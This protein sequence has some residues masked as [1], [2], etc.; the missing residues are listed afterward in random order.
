MVPAR[1]EPGFEH[2]FQGLFS[3][4]VPGLCSGSNRHRQ[5][6]MLAACIKGGENAISKAV[7]PT[8]R[9]N[10][11]KMRITDNPFRVFSYFL[12]YYP[13]P[14]SDLTLISFYIFKSTRT[15]PDLD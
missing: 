6:S 4:A 5:Q 9:L 7:G 15:R 11:K 14:E 10:G 1:P 8:G 2:D 12:K 13:S 3:L